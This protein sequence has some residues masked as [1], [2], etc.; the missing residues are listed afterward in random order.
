ME[1]WYKLG[2]HHGEQQEND[3]DSSSSRCSGHALGGNMVP[4]GLRYVALLLSHCEGL[5]RRIGNAFLGHDGKYS[6]V[7]GS[8]KMLSALS[9]GTWYLME[10]ATWFFAEIDS[11]RKVCHSESS[12]CCLDHTQANSRQSSLDRRVLQLHNN[13]CLSSYFQSKGRI[14][15]L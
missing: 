13:G 5:L 9:G 1:A 3:N 4:L 11:S 12:I 15:R 2:S 7:H 10:Y 14:S 8:V 6:T